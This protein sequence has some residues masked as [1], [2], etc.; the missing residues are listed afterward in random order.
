MVNKF[1]HCQGRGWGIVKRD[2]WGYCYISQLGEIFHHGD[3]ESLTLSTYSKFYLIID[4]NLSSLYIL[5]RLGFT[6]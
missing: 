5:A 2:G 1:L 4:L 3:R 6:L